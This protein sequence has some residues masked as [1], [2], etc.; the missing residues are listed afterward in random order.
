MEKFRANRLQYGDQNEIIED[1]W[2]GSPKASFSIIFECVKS[3]VK[4]TAITDQSLVIFYIHEDIFIKIT[5][6]IIITICKLHTY[7]I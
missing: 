6:L 3:V 5:L 4:T 1:L 2:K 7:I